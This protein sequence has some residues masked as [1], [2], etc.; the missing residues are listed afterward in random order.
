M[1]TIQ[2]AGGNQAL[3]R[4]RII[5]VTKDERTRDVPIPSVLGSLIVATIIA[6]SSLTLETDSVPVP[7]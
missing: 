3:Q 2:I 5:T 1:K 6:T 4:L 7:S